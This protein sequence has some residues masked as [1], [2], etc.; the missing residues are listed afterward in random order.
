[1][2]FDDEILSDD[3]NE[4]YDDQQEAGDGSRK[5]YYDFVDIRCNDLDEE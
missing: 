2:W 5:L 3:D 4:I 1:M